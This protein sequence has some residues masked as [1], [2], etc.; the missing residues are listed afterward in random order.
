MWLYL[1]T[2]SSL[3][4]HPPLIKKKWIPYSNP[5]K[6]IKKNLNVKSTAIPTKILFLLPSFSLLLTLLRHYCSQP[7]WQKPIL[8]LHDFSFYLLTFLI[9]LNALVSFSH[10]IKSFFQQE[11][12][13][14]LA[15]LGKGEI[16][17]WP[18]MISFG[19]LG[20]GKVHKHFLVNNV[21]CVILWGARTGSHEHIEQESWI[22]SC[23]SKDLKEQESAGRAG[24]SADNIPNRRRSPPVEDWCHSS[25]SYR[26]LPLLSSSPSSV[27]SFFPAFRHGFLPLCLCNSPDQCSVHW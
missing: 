5:L 1:C 3:L 7:I 16:L 25:L 23:L 22:C 26:M 19:K 9:S 4:Q 24:G 11:N 2:H 8:S 12:L 10:C 18:S 27:V 6:A 21:W 15:E 20:E 17:D 14:S 13:S